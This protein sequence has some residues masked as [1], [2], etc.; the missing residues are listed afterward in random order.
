M[1]SPI[2]HPTHAAGD[3]SDVA[4]RVQA[5]AGELLRIAHA[6]H[7]LAEPAFAE[8]RS[9]AL[10]AGAAARHGLR[11]TRGVGG[12]RTAFVAEAGYRGPVVAIFCEYDALPGLGHACGHNIV[13]AA[14]LGAAIVLAELANRVGG[15]VRLIGSPAEEGGGGKIRLAAAGLLREVRAA[16]LVHPNAFETARPRIVAAVPLAVRTYG[17]AAHAS[18]FPERGIN[19]LD[20][21]VL[22]YTGLWAGRVA[23]PEGGQVH[24]VLRHGGRSPGV[25]PDL[26]EAALLIRAPT[27]D[28][29][30]PVTAAVLRPWRAGAAAVGARLRVQPTGPAYAHLRTDPWL[31]AAWDRHV[32]ALGR[33]PLP[34]S[35]GRRVGSS[36]L[37]NVSHLV[38]AIHPMIA[39]GGDD[40]VPHTAAFAAA[41]VSP[42]AD[43]AVLDG[44]TALALTALDAWRRPASPT[45]TGSPP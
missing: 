20:A 43:R 11:V 4:C 41:A 23:L 2:A 7:R 9:A 40:A 10:L 13:A 39:I 3:L 28:A 38:P 26:A 31:A 37:G 8:H 27:L 5:M 30:G 32:F 44:A 36:D 17:R 21:L 1:S 34:R 19:A 18:L 16:M 25:I 6:V 45:T 35:P 29:L 15:R 42:R 14:G 33:A 24:A 12:L 22:G